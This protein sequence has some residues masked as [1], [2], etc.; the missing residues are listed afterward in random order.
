MLGW[1]LTNLHNNGFKNGFFTFVTSYMLR[2][3]GEIRALVCTKLHIPHKAESWRYTTLRV[4]CLTVSIFWQKSFCTMFQ[5][6]YHMQAIWRDDT[7]GT[8]YHP[9]RNYTSYNLEI[10]KRTHTHTHTHRGCW[11]NLQ[12]REYWKVR[13]IQILHCGRKILSLSSG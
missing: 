11:L 5:S 8:I 10:I 6:C 12:V 3:K 1:P 7:W 9:T 13:W 4:S 2:F